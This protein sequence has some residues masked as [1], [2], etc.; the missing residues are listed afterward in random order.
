M[1]TARDM[2]K[3][4]HGQSYPVYNVQSLSH[5]FSHPEPELVTNQSSLKPYLAFSTP[6]YF[7]EALRGL[8]MTFEQVNWRAV[9]DGVYGKAD[10]EAD[11]SMFAAKTVDGSYTPIEPIP[12][13]SSSSGG[14]NKIHEIQYNGLYL[15]SEKLWVGEAVRL[16]PTAEGGTGEHTDILIVSAIIERLAGHSIQD[17]ILVG[18]IYT[19]RT[20][21]HN[22]ARRIP[23]NTYLPLRLQQDLEY[24]NAAA[25]RAKLDKVSHWKLVTPRARISVAEVKGRWY[26]SKHVLPIVGSQQYAWDKQASGKVPDIGDLINARGD[27]AAAPVT[28]GERKGN[29]LQAFGLSVPR[30]T[31]I[32]GKIEQSQTQGQP[33]THGQSSRPGQ[34]QPPGEQGGTVPGD[35]VMSEYLEAKK[36]E[37][38]NYG[39]GYTGGHY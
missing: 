6:E 7:H 11:A 34:Q 22:P 28:I 35:S 9:L 4:A 25:L 12:T 19:W 31:Q 3:N 5:P 21:K 38:S 13:M 17:L 20:V 29:R 14:H 1:V 10:T 33:Q 24:R 23:P 30:G 26:E 8:N 27:S 2:F 37:G 15:G 36:L 39:Q 18:D 16:R 32:G